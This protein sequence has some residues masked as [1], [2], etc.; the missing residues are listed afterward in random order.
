M[1]EEVI[2]EDIGKI[3][4]DIKNSLIDFDKKWTLYEEKYIS[5]LI[6]IEK[7]SRRYIFEGI[8]I[9]KELTQYE[10]KASI[11]GRM[12]I[13]NDKEYNEIRERFVKIINELNN[14]ANINGKG[15]D[16]LDRKSV[17]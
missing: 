1:Y 9:E 7:I 14:I 5:E 11:R 17:V 16:D 8:K 12:N 2:L 15:R 4:T 3:K 13:S 6:Y 10:K